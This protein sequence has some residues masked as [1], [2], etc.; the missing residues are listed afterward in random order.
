MRLNVACVAIFMSLDVVCGY[1][2]V[3]VCQSVCIVCTCQLLSVA[4]FAC[5]IL[6]GGDGT[7]RTRGAVAIGS[8][9]MPDI[10]TFLYTRLKIS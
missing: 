5:P 2:S 9:N 8:K 3:S 6:F 7:S 4:V 10:E 1:L